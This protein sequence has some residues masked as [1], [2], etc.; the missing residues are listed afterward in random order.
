MF[1]TLKAAVRHSVRQRTWET[2]NV[3]S[4]RIPSIFAPCAARNSRPSGICKFTWPFTRSRQFRA[5]FAVSWKRAKL[6]WSSTC[7]RILRRDPTNVKCAARISKSRRPWIFIWGPTW[8]S[9]P[10]NV[11]CA[12]WTL[13]TTAHWRITRRNTTRKL[14][15][16]Y[17]FYA[18]NQL[19]LSININSKITGV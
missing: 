6:C 19:F 14:C 1:A 10:L 4:T 12:T 9:D 18:I 16:L 5:K 15:N 7:W 11:T 3:T 17:I 13:P 8:T 2:T